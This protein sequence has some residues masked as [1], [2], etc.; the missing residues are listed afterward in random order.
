MAGLRGSLNSRQAA[1]ADKCTQATPA[2]LPPGIPQKGC[3]ID[4]ATQQ[5]PQFGRHCTPSALVQRAEI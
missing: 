3:E 1:S 5:A 2:G 4:G